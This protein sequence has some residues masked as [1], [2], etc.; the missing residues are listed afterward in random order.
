MVGSSSTA[1]TSVGPQTTGGAIASHSGGVPTPQP[2]GVPT[3]HSGGGAPAHNRPPPPAHVTQLTSSPSLAV[4]HHPPTQ[5]SHYSRQLPPVSPQQRSRSRSQGGG[6]AS[7]GGVPSQHYPNNL[8]MMAPSPA[9]QLLPSSVNS[10]SL[11]PQHIPVSSFLPPPL[12]VSSP[13]SPAGQLRLVPSSTA[14][15][16]DNVIMPPHAF[17]KLTRTP[18][19]DE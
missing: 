8:P 9:H 14:A 12:H 18:A 1:N 2:G 17:K 7:R 3:P 11:I 15:A 10:P 16:A 5:Q 13:R 19:E 4:V 6:G